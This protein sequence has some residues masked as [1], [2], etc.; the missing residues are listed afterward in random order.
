MKL[1]AGI[2]LGT[3]VEVVRWVAYGTMA[4]AAAGLAL[5]NS[6]LPPAMLLVGGLLALIGYAADCHVHFRLEFDLASIWIGIL[7]ASDAIFR[8]RDG[9]MVAAGE[10]PDAP[11]RGVARKVQVYQFYFGFL[12][13]LQFGVQ[14][15]VSK[16]WWSLA[17]GR[18]PTRLPAELNPELYSEAPV[19]EDARGSASGGA[20]S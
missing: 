8:L 6:W 5:T 12:P 18:V 11:V 4:G 19:C 9:G 1:R 3:S 15:T 20:A 17:P 16:D 7:N 2:V 10:A 14:W 13:C